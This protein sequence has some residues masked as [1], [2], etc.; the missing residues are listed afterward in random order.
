GAVI[1]DDDQDGYLEDGESVSYRPVITNS[2]NVTLR[3]AVVVSSLQDV[4][5]C[6]A[7]D[8]AP[9][10]SFECPEQVHDITAGDVKAGKIVNRLTPGAVA[11]PGAVSALPV[12]L[13]TPITPPPVE[14][15][16]QLKLSLTGSP[17]GA[18]LGDTVA[19][20]LRVGN[21]GTDPLDDL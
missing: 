10:G 14:H 21:T 1:H 8:L 16:P 15:R 11:P 18:G 9:R 13:E 20:R 17:A 19:F 5:P 2:G 3:T 4:S 6:L 7:A 12:V